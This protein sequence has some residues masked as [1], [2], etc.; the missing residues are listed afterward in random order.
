MYFLGDGVRDWWCEIV[1]DL[2]VDA[3]KSITW[4]DFV[5]RFKREFVLTIEV[6]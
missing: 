4:E 2:K 3:V 1:R 6:Q 5:T